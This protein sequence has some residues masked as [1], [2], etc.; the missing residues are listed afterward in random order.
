MRDNSTLLHRLSLWAQD[1]PGQ[2]ALHFKTESGAWSSI[3][4][5]DYWLSVVRIADGLTAQKIKRGDRILIYAVTSPE[6]MQWELGILLAGGVSVGLHPHLPDRDLQSIVAQVKPRFAL[7]PENVF[8]DRLNGVDQGSD[9][10][11]SVHTFAEAEAKFLIHVTSEPEVLLRRGDQL[12]KKIKPTDSQFIVFT[13]GTTG[14]PKGVKLGLSQLTYVSDVVTREWNLPFSDGNLFSFLPL[15]HIAEKIQSMGVAISERYPVWFNSKY[16]NFF[17][18]IREVRPSM[19]LAVPRVWERFK[20][21]VEVQK[22]KV[23]QRVMEIERLG[24]FAE[25]MYLNQAR[26]QI[27]LDRLKLAVSGAVKLA[28]S[29][30]EGFKGIGIE[31]QEIY[32]MSESCGL[33]TL[34]HAKRKGFDSVG[35]AP[36]GLQ[37]KVATDGEIWIKGPNLFNGYWEDQAL[38]DSVLMEDGWLKTGDLGEWDPELKIIGRNRDIIKLSNGRMIAPSPIE[39]ALKEI[40]E[41]SNACLVGEGKHGLLALIT[42]KENVLMEY[43]FIP[44]AIEGLSVEAEDLKEKIR[45]AIDELLLQNKIAEKIPNFIILSREFSTDHHEVTLTQKL[46]RSRIHQNFRHFIEFKFEEY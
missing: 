19:L 7:V 17:S 1:Q 34:T 35:V 9:G 23:L 15:A 13:S 3:T 28:P 37:V 18:E 33:A 16:E 39:N 14:T 44:G 46:N 31:I 42:L 32:G 38:T 11:I 24:P 8:R 2:P 12:L 21:K 45:S 22:P 30:A 40:P 4:A 26:E 20:E 5:G 25:R 27:G 10:K 6:W 29:V 41:V 36:A 43:K